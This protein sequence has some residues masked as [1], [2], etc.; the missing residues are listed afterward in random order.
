MGCK[1]QVA[2]FNHSILILP[3]LEVGLSAHRAIHIFGY[4]GEAVKERSL[5]LKR[6]WPDI[7]Q[8]ISGWE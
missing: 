5:I 6:I 4:L 1:P 7:F 8:H 3:V 2:L